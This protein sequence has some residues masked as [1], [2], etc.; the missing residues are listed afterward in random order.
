MPIVS[1]GGGGGNTTA[2]VVASGKVLPVA[3]P[4]SV[5]VDSTTYDDP[6]AGGGAKLKTLVFGSDQGALGIALLGDA[7][8]RWIMASDAA[9]G[10]FLG[11][12]TFDPYNSALAVLKYGAGLSIGRASCLKANTSVGVPRISQLSPLFDILSGALP[13]QQFVSGASAGLDANDRETHT[14]VTFNP[15]V[16]TTATCTVALS[17][18]DVTF[19]TLA[20]ITKPVGVA[21]DG[22]IEDV[23]VRVPGGWTL[24]LTV[25][26][27]VLGL[28]TYY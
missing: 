8:P 17:A 10:F 5:T 18:D 4:A 23:T 2:Q 1:G 6:I 11:N 21:F 24:K 14:P 7:F 19:S 13:T 9:D 16:A 26:N 27:A 22:E 28:T 15:G 3:N 25:V 20:V 12:G